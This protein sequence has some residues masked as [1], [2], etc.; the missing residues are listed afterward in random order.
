M[1]TGGTGIQISAYLLSCDLDSYAVL[2]RN[3]QNFQAYLPVPYLP[4]YSVHFFLSLELL[5]M[6]PQ[7]S[8]LIL[9]WCFL[10]F[11]P[12]ARVSDQDTD[13]R[14]IGQQ[15]YVNIRVSLPARDRSHVLLQHSL[16]SFHNLTWLL[17]CMRRRTT[18]ATWWR[19]LQRLYWRMSS[20]QRPRS[21]THMLRM[22]HSF[23]HPW[24]RS[25]ADV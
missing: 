11:S 19:E 21:G 2:E 8:L 25:W 6:N 7:G 12:Q 9:T 24:P 22:W 23:W 5:M 16:A 17:T 13:N 4:A 14:F 18:A 15:I 10:F 1:F 3:S 20:S